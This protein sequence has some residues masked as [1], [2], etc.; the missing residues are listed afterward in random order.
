MLLRKGKLKEETTKTT[1]NNN[2][3]NN[4]SDNND[5]D[6]D[7]DEKSG[8]TPYVICVY[9]FE[10]FSCIKSFNRISNMLFFIYFTFEMFFIDIVIL[11]L[12]HL[13]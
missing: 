13:K 9:N 12:A 8:L 10:G 4:N 3:N 5:D 2:N 6:D 7:D 11:P 1:T